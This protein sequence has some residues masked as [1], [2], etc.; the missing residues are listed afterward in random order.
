[1]PDGKRIIWRHFDEN[2]TTAD[3]YT[4]ALDGAAVRRLTD[5]ASMSWAPYFHPSGRY[6]IF[7][8]NKLGFSNFELY[9]VDVD[10]EHEPVRVTFTE[11][12]DGLPVFS[13][14]GNRL[15][16]TSGR[17]PDGKSQL[18]LADW[19]HEAALAAITAAPM[20][21]RASELTST[22]PAPRALP[23]RFGS[24]KDSTIHGQDAP[25]KS[26]RENLRSTV[27]YLASDALDGRMTGTK[28]AVLAADYIASQLRQA[29]LRPGG[30]DGDYFQDFQFNSGVRVITNRNRLVIASAG[31][32]PLSFAVEEDFRPLSFSASGVVTGS[33]VFAGYGLFVP[34]APGEGYDSYAGLDVTNKMVLLLRYVPEDVSPKRRQELNRDGGL[35]YQAMLD[36]ERG[37]KAVLFVTAPNSPK[38]GELATLSFDSGL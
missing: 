27:E 10:G 17:A 14:D 28:G 32:P 26:P 22:A 2:G 13:P 21:I 9:L 11:G 4:M 37:A 19:R 25:A 16:W 12:F 1:S 38:A 36:R 7:T 29:G 24:S 3:I 34:G 33:V 6:V 20:R 15:C 31:K 8:S 23:A 18:F 30:K 5:F 35:R